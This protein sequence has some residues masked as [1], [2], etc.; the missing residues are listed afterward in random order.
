M[1]AAIRFELGTE[2][3]DIFLTLSRE[4]PKCRAASRWLIPPEQARRN[5]PMQ[6]HGENTSALPV[7]RKGQTGQLLH[8]P[9]RDNPAA[10]V[11]D[12]CAAVLKDRGSRK[13]WHRGP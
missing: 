4:I 6:I 3:L 13:I 2:K 12:Y 5:L 1:N 9:Q 7:T 10:T 8:R 11:D